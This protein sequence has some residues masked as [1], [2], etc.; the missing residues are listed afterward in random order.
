MNISHEH[1]R[2]V[3]NV[4]MLKT[5]TSLTLSSHGLVSVFF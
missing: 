5:F 1:L 2:A 3:T 4:F